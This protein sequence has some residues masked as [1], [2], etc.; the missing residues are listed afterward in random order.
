MHRLKHNFE[1]IRHTCQSKNKVPWRL[2]RPDFLSFVS[3]RNDA[4]WS[5]AVNHEAGNQ[6]AIELCGFERYRFGFVVVGD[7][8]GQIKEPTEAVL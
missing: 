3:E 4:G 6:N 8:H 5:E 1:L 7:A 2:R